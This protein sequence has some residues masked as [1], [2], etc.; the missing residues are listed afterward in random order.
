ME[1]SGED[2]WQPDTNCHP[3]EREATME[4]CATEACILE[5]RVGDWSSCSAECGE[6]HQSR[7]VQCSVANSSRGHCDRLQ[8]PADRRV[9][10]VPTVTAVGYLA[11][12]YLHWRLPDAGKK[13]NCYSPTN[14]IQLDVNCNHQRKP[15][16]VSLCGSGSCSA[17]WIAQTWNQV[18]KM[19]VTTVATASG[20]PGSRSELPGVENGEMVNMMKAD[21]VTFKCQSRGLP[22]TFP[23][24]VALCSP[25]RLACSPDG[26]R[27][28]GPSV[29]SRAEAVKRGGRSAV[30][31]MVLPPTGV[32]GI[33]C[34]QQC[35]H[36]AWEI[37]QSG[38]VSTSH[39]I[40]QYKVADV[41]GKEGVCGIGRGVVIEADSQVG[42]GR[43]S[44]IGTSDG[45][46]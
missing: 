35:I 17:Q 34:L 26:T 23:P 10:E 33:P 14:S 21:A 20:V 37:V 29:L 15:L 32:T 3:V 1:R 12:A 2:V 11:V 5:W 9:C 43:D 8:R 39:I 30:T 22:V 45:S 13:M 16:S 4:E 41:R 42:K 6:G 44:H 24:A 40:L 19:Y 25:I 31:R 46:F 36:V 18:T 27:Q 38:K 28:S 7:V